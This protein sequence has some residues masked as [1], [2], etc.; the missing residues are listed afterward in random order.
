MDM[1][2]IPYKMP[3]EACA[4]LRTKY[5]HIYL[6]LILGLFYKVT[7]SMVIRPL[8]DRTYCVQYWSA[9]THLGLWRMLYDCSG[10]K[11]RVRKCL[12]KCALRT[13]SS[14]SNRLAAIRKED[15]STQVWWLGRTWRSGIGPFPAQG[16]VEDSPTQ[17]PQLEGQLR[18]I[19]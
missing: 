19:F 13:F 14:I 6:L 9:Y 16:P 10:H 12:I 17:T 18:P 1:R 15:Y 8:D 3:N 5:A 2:K 7:T 11:L 4:N